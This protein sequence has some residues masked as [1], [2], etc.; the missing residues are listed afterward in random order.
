MGILHNLAGLFDV[1]FIRLGGTVK[2]N[3]SEAAVDTVFADFIRRAVV[4]VKDD[5]DFRDAQLL[6]LLPFW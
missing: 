3:G 4:E 6:L 2:H 5:R 1:F